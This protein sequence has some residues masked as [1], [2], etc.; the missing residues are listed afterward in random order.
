MAN[1][2]VFKTKGNKITQK[3]KAGKHN[4]IDLVGTGSTLDYIVA[5]SDGTVTAVRKDCN[6]TYKTGSS[7]GNYVKIKH[8]NGYYTLYAHLKYGS[9]SVKVGDKVKKGQVIGY[10]GNTG[11][12][13]GAHLHWEVRNTKDVN[14]P[15]TIY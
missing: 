7:Y 15:Y 10:M 3:Y 13:F 1:S 9:V 14:R 6:A 11:H 12:S 5:H 8:T 4:G 2:R